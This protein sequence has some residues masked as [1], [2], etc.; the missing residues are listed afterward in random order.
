MRVEYD[1]IFK[2]PAFIEFLAGDR[3]LVLHPINAK[4]QI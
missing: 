4:I 2:V 1:F 3:V